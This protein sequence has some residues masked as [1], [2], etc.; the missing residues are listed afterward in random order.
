MSPSSTTKMLNKEEE[1]VKKDEPIKPKS[2]SKQ[3]WGLAKEG[4]TTIGNAPTT[5]ATTRILSFKSEPRYSINEL[6]K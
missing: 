4:G 6:H 3:R 2:S 5:A 1:Q